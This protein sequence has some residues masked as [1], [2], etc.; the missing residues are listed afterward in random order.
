[1][2]T[3]LSNDPQ[4]ALTTKS[5]V[6]SVIRLG[7]IVVLAW[8]AFAVFRPFT[9]IMLWGLLLAIMVYPLHQKLAAHTDG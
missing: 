3:P 9:L 5:F 2:N 4:P 1:M 6:D 7:V 8:L